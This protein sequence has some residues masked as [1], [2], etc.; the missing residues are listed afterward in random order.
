ME[1]A[2]IIA[3]VNRENAGLQAKLR[4]VEQQLF[5][6]HNLNNAFKALFQSQTFEIYTATETINSLHQHI[7]FLQSYIA[8]VEQ[9]SEQGMLACQ[10]TA[11]FFQRE[12][13]A[14]RWSS[15]QWYEEAASLSSGIK[16]LQ[17]T[18]LT[19]I[20]S[21][22]PTEEQTRQ[23]IEKITEIESNVLLKKTQNNDLKNALRGKK[24][25]LER[26][27]TTTTAMIDARDDLN[28]K[29]IAA[30]D[31][32]RSNAGRNAR[33]LNTVKREQGRLKKELANAEKDLAK[34]EETRVQLHRIIES[35]EK[36]QCEYQTAL[37]KAEDQR[38]STDFYKRE[39]SNQVKVILSLQRKVATLQD[40]EQKSGYTKIIDDQKAEIA[41]L[42]SSQA[43][44]EGKLQ[45]SERIAEQSLARMVEQVSL[46]KEARKEAAISKGHALGTASSLLASLSNTKT[47]FAK[48]VVDAVF[49]LL[50]DLDSQQK[51]R[52]AIAQVKGYLS[53]QG[54]V[55]YDFAESVASNGGEVQDVINDLQQRLPRKPIPEDL[56]GYIS[57]V[58][59]LQCALETKISN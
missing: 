7:H 52:D 29:L 48:N 33:T 55:V 37:A 53:R 32:L 6:L 10:N 41:Q 50:K 9:K 26:L 14:E 58:S 42:I 13:A 15:R 18:A 45:K 17:N 19:K 39:D 4:M 51:A 2:E 38:L 44:L 12:L 8:H 54:N 25:R 30:N 22:Q 35:E 49:A 11:E 28:R 36:L 47:V 56:T 21:S 16:D 40:A 57:Y 24:N 3:S 5:D 20:Q 43:Q 27:Q 46:A 59:G 31:T 34:Y 23:L 1:P